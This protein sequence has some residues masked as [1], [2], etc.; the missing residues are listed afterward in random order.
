MKNEI[1]S[2]KKVIFIVTAMVC[3]D[4]GPA[5]YFRSTI[6]NDKSNGNVKNTNQMLQNKKEK[7]I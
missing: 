6:I 2:K 4:L 1:C 7:I 5:R 3:S